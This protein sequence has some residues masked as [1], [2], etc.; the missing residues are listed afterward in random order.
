MQRTRWICTPRWR[1][2]YV[3]RYTRPALPWPRLR[4][5]PPLTWY[6][7]TKCSRE[8]TERSSRGT[9]SIGREPGW[10]TDI[11]RLPLVLNAYRCTNRLVRKGIRCTCW[12]VNA[13]TCWRTWPFVPCCCR[14]WGRGS[15][16][17]RDSSGRY[18]CF[19]TSAFRMGKTWLHPVIVWCI[20]IPLWGS[21]LLVY[22]G[23]LR[24]DPLREETQ[25]RLST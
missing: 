16:V 22:F 2:F 8:T 9:G 1:V 12:F 5:R 11:F 20:S 15:P 3:L 4:H 6:P 18:R 17:T 14:R 13:Q 10:F 21:E 19:D 23:D 24:L 25:N 7:C